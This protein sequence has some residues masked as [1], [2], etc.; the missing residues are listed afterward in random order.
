MASEPEGA[1][2]VLVGH[3]GPDSWM[4]KS[5]VRRALCGADV[6]L[7]DTPEDLDGVIDTADLLLVNRALDGGFAG[8][9]GVAMIAELSQRNRAPA[10]ML[11]SN[12]A[13]AQEE[14]EAAGALPGFGKA[15]IGSERMRERLRAALHHARRML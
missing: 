11:V 12:Y 2:V 9:S 10:L 15:E 6:L 7:V 14:A 5:A 13:D 8:A 3:C 4:L 1:T